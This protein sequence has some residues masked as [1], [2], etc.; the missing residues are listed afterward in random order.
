LTPANEAT[1][2]PAPLASSEGFGEAYLRHFAA[3]HGYF[4]ARVLDAHAADDLCQEVFFRAFRER[5]QFRPEGEARPWLMGIARNVLSEYVRKARRSREVG[6]AELCLELEETVAAHRLYEDFMPY[7]SI[8][9]LE[10]GDSAREALNWHYMLG[11]KLQEIAERLNRSI[12]AV[13]VLMLRARH[14]LKRCLEARLKG[15]TR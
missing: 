4:R 15:A 7:L 5:G 13:K 8:C 3:V 10:L 6:W 12:G 14:A 9:V 11:L 2:P 1:Q